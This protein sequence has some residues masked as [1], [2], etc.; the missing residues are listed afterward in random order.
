LNVARKKA[1]GNWNP[2]WESWARFDPSWT[3]K[4]VSMSITPAVSGALDVKT[5][6]LI[7]IALDAS[8]PQ[9]Y[10][11]GVRRHIRRALEAGAT[12]QEIIAVLQLVSMQGLHTMCLAAPILVE[13]LQAL[14]RQPRATPRKTPKDKK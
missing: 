8:S 10:A 11:P 14:D 2:D 1:S 13:Q 9:L 12:R 6:E 5:I 7:R 4:A 3:D